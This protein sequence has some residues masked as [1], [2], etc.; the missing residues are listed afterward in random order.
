MPK[1]PYQ[2]NLKLLQEWAENS[3][4]SIFARLDK[5]LAPSV[6]FVAV[7]ENLLVGKFTDSPTVIRDNVHI[8]G[9]EDPE[10]IFEAFSSFG[11]ELQQVEPKIAQREIPPL[12]VPINCY[13]Y[14][15]QKGLAISIAFEN[16]INQ[17]GSCENKVYFSDSSVLRREDRHFVWPMLRLNR[18]KYEGHY[19]L[20]RPV[21]NN[22]ASTSLLNLTISQFLHACFLG[23]KDRSAGIDPLLVTSKSILTDSARTMVSFLKVS[24]LSNSGLASTQLFEDFNA[25]S[26]LPYEK[27][28]S[29]GRVIIADQNHQNIEVKVRFTQPIAISNDRLARKTLEMAQGDLFLL[30]DTRWLYGLGTIHGQYDPSGEDLFEVEFTSQNTWK[31]FHGPNRTNEMMLVDLGRPKLPSKLIPQEEFRVKFSEQFR[32]IKDAE[33]IYSLVEAATGQTHGALIIIS[34][35]AVSEAQRFAGQC[36]LVDPFQVNC[37]DIVQLTAIDG[38]VLIDH[39]GQCHALGVILDGEAAGDGEPSRG[40]RYNSAF[41]YV[42]TMRNKYDHKCIAAVISSDGM[43]NL[44]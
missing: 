3:A 31:L 28:E 41:R 34:D 17:T 37:E 4:R 2:T 27:R 5:S 36:V 13:D 18:K 21:N 8:L 16:G 38:A 42:S 39:Q 1:M 15:N 40:S 29:H 23:I 12:T 24:P 26:A 9:D 30:C 22:L 33:T 19:A 20:R 14:P 7:S 6:F 44:L 43:V 35:Q 11:N 25:I 32:E 10:V